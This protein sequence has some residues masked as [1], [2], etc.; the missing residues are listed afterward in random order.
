MLYLD[1]TTHVGF[2]IWIFR[3]Q[4][5]DYYTIETRIFSDFLVGCRTMN[6]SD[7]LS[8]NWTAVTE[9]C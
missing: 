7:I 9:E 8:S 5:V 1:L 6:F 2:F 3:L 4:T